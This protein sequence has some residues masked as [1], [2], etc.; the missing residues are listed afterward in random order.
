M[1]EW[2]IRREDLTEAQRDVADLIGLEN[3]RKLVELC[4]QYPNSR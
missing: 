2:E 4:A 3:Y 1:S